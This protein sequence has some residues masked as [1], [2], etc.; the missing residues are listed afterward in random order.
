MRVAVYVRCSTLDQHPETQL[1]ELRTYCAARGWTNVREYVDHGESGAN[2]KRPALDRLLVDAKAMRIDTICVIG[3][4]RLGRSVGHVVQILELLRHLGITFL[5]LRE[6]LDSASPV[7]AA[8]F[9]IIAVLGQLERDLIRSRVKAGLRRAKLEGRRL[10]RQPLQVDPRRLESALARKLSARAAA[11][12]L[13]C[14]TASA[15]RLIRAR[16]ADAHGASRA[17]EEAAHA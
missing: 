8:L 17:A 2:T 11:R 4:D 12:E 1:L 6:Q 5:S 13:G 9:A 14:S 15:W 10:G 7:G 3:L 16:A